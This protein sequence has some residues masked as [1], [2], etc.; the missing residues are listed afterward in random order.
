[1][2]LSQRPTLLEETVT[3]QLNSKFVFRTV[4]ASDIETI[5]QETD[6]TAEEAKRL[7]YL[8]SGDTFVSSAI[9]GRTMAVRI[10]VAK[11]TSPHTENPFDELEARS[12]EAVENFYK[13]AEE[14]LPIYETDL[15][16]K[17]K[18]INSKLKGTVLSRN[19]L[20]AKLEELV[21]EGKVEKEESPLGGNVYNLEK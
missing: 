6:L 18:E 2:E 7:P 14:Y 10:R 5:K 12:K 19:E 3:A 20:V 8:S 13:I 11:T 9:F 15:L 16:T 17:L 4:R 21:D 1:M